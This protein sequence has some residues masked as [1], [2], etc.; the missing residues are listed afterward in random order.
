MAVNQDAVTGTTQAVDPL[1]KSARVT[2]RPIETLAWQS[3]GAKTG[4]ITGLAANGAIFSLRNVS[5]NLI[6]IRRVGVGYIC[7]TAFTTAQTVDFGLS[8]AR[9]FTASDS[10]GTAI[11]VTGSNGKHRTSLA[12]VTS[13]DARISAA[14]AL[15]AGTKVLDTNNIGVV[16]AWIGAI[17]AGINPTQDNLLS[18]N[19]GDYPLVLAQN[20][21][22]NILNLTAMGATGVGNAYVNIEFAEVA[23][24]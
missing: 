18:H 5:A 23:T 16:G 11:A 12:T 10:A 20:E 6:V 21:G 14:A 17:G 1:H 9:A 15:T 2:L 22:I 13:L 24:Y 7:T 19:T 4:L 3:I 8:I